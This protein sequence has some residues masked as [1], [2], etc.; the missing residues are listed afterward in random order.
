MSLYF[1]TLP[2]GTYDIIAK[3]LKSFKLDELKIVEHDDSSVTFQSSLTMERL[4][5]LR[6]FTNV[7]LVADKNL[8]IPKS[9]FN[10]KY[11]RLMLL[12]NGSPQPINQS[13][14]T[15]LETKIRQELGLEPNTHLSKND[16]YLIER[17]SGKKLFT[18]RLPRAKFKREKLSS[19]ELRPE[20]ANILCLVAGIKAKHRVLDVFAGYGSISYEAVRGFGCKQVI[21]IDQQKLAGRHEH[22][23]I[24]WHIADARSLA[25]IPDCSVDRVVT[26]PPWGVYDESSDLDD[27][28]TQAFKELYRVTKPEAIV[29]ILSGS[30]VLT[31]IAENSED[32]RLIKSFPVLV[33]GKKAK[34]L[35]LQ[36][37]SNNG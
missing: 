33:S 16:F 31:D 2:A 1:A 25:F 32:F 22:S 10:G 36:K 35:K 27:I 8:E 19:G 18:L 11:Y 28:Y 29:V 3:Q 23:L 15:N 24:E 37:V 14:R 21:A 9:V 12:K 30:E 26:D 17:A 5:E 13:E 4:V 34:I 7:Y 20:L 6:Y